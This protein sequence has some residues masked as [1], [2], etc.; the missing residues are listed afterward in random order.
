MHYII[1]KTHSKK[2]YLLHKNYIV[3]FLHFRIACT[4]FT[5]GSL[6]YTTG[7]VHDIISIGTPV[8]LS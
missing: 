4:N 2:N 6:E 3:F 8:L 7:T 1:L 5:L